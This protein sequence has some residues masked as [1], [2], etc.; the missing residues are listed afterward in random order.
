MSIST[1]AAFF[2]S[3]CARAYTVDALLRPY[4][5]PDAARTFLHKQ[6]ALSRPIG[7]DFFFASFSFRHFF[8]LI[9][10]LCLFGEMTE[11][12]HPGGYLFEILSAKVIDTPSRT[13]ASS[14]VFGARVFSSTY[15][16]KSIPIVH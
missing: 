5:K 6:G 2:S 7:D 1:E 11:R 3:Q 8:F 16:A 15:K 9:S 12:N 13:H 4:T 10:L 14:R